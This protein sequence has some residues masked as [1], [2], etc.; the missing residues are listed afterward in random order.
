MV[1]GIRS[2]SPG[3]FGAQMTSRPLS[4]CLVTNEAI[5]CSSTWP[6]I[7]TASKTDLLG[8]SWRLI[9]TSP[10]ARSRSIRRVLVPV[11]AK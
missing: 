2:A 10:K 1:T 8:I 7:A 4:S 9:A 11:L 3:S 6:A 5:A